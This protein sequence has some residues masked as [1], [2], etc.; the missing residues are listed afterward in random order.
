MAH[1]VLYEYTPQR[2]GVPILTRLTTAAG[3]TSR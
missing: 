2:T 3:N 1:S